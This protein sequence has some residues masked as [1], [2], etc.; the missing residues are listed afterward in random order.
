MGKAKKAR[1]AARAKAKQEGPA[2]SV[3]QDP[4]SFSAAVKALKKKA[5]KGVP[6]DHAAEIPRLLEMYAKDESED[7][8]AMLKGLLEEANKKTGGRTR[9]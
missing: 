2:A 8:D 5:K 9:L 6:V 1:A 3:R 7:K 4:A